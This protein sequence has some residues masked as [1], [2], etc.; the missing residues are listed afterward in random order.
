M[1]GAAAFLEEGDPFGVRTP[2]SC[3]AEI[4]QARFPLPF[5]FCVAHSRQTCALVGSTVTVSHACAFVEKQLARPAALP[6]WSLNCLLLLLAPC[7]AAAVPLACEVLS[8]AAQLPEGPMQVAEAAEAVAGREWWRADMR[9]TNLLFSTLRKALAAGAAVRDA[10]RL[11]QLCCD[12]VRGTFG[13]GTR[14][15]LQV[16]A[17][18]LLHCGPGGRHA[19]VLAAAAELCRAA[20]AHRAAGTVG[21]HDA[22]IAAA[23]LLA[24]ERAVARQP[25]ETA[26]LLQALC[27]TD[28][29]SLL[30]VAQLAARGPAPPA[31]L[32]ALLEGAA[33]SCDALLDDAAAYQQVYVGLAAGLARAPLPQAE[34]WLCE[35]LLTPHVVS[36]HLL[37][38]LWAFVARNAA[39]AVQLRHL[40]LLLDCCEALTPRRQC[41]RRAAALLG[42]ALLGCPPEVQAEFLVARP[43]ALH[44][45]PAK[46]DTR[47]EV[48]AA[49]CL[50]ISQAMG[51]L[52]ADPGA[53]VRLAA[54]CRVGASHLT[55][56]VAAPLAQ[57]VREVYLRLGASASSVS[58]RDQR[59]AVVLLGSL[60][61][62]FGT[63]ELRKY[64]GKLLHTRSLSPLANV[65]FVGRVAPL[66][67]GGC[68]DVVAAH[69]GTAFNQ[70]PW[71]M[72]VAALHAFRLLSTECLSLD[73]ALLQ[74]LA[75]PPHSKQAEA[76]MA[77]LSMTSAAVRS[78]LGTLLQAQAAASGVPKKAAT[79]LTL[80]PAQD[81]AGLSMALV[82]TV[83]ALH[84]LRDTD[85]AHSER[86]QAELAQALAM[87]GALQKH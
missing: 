8:R 29:A 2:P 6:G 39:R 87:L 68:V 43:E 20:R 66:I 9:L 34:A 52:S 27:A 24:A 80:L 63:D 60:A 25:L 16:L 15:F 53:V 83:K 30:L 35:H 65:A 33:A 42:A 31:L 7:G 26:P 28:A 14:F 48:A 57:S 50:Q 3:R 46:P 61:M 1:K 13:R 85:M 70:K 69:L 17:D 5:F 75:G 11:V 84:S 21:E 64:L 67:D 23:A 44:R 74:Q 37:A 71:Y 36:A 76:V 54:L 49:A 59:A 45:L 58:A 77:F 78:D 4:D 86:F 38:Q 18:L 41:Q 62:W 55:H 22:P 81:F 51:Q 19:A 10:G 79:T 72:R 32:S 40:H 56:A 12:A 73:A 47:E 82:S